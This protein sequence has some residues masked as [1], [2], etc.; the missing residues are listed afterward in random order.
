QPRPHRRAVRGHDLGRPVRLRR[1]RG[2]R[3]GRGEV[4]RP[5]SGRR[6]ATVVMATSDIVASACAWPAFHGPDGHLS[7]L[8]VPIITVPALVPAP[9]PW[10]VRGR[11]SSPRASRPSGPPGT[12]LCFLGLRP[13]G[14]A[15]APSPA[16]PSSLDTKGLRL[17]LRLRPRRAEPDEPLGR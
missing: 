13:F 12:E 15:Q 14:G 10:L 11:S 6:K 8:F 5:E 7:L 2:L 3:P 16:K 17:R 4:A 1:R 9:L